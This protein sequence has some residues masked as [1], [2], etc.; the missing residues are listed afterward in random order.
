MR[1]G[2]AGYPLDSAFAW[3]SSKEDSDGPKNEV[4]E[5][6]DAKDTLTS[7]HPIYVIP[8]RVVQRCRELFSKKTGF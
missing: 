4:L 7:L 5:L 6:I 2:E 1:H 8:W 3:E